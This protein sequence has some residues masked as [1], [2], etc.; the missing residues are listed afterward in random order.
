LEK[1]DLLSSIAV[2]PTVIVL[3]CVAGET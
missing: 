3:A 2:A 1:I